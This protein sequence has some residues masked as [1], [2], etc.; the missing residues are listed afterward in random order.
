MLAQYCH[1]ECHGTTA[2]LQHK[3]SAMNVG[4]LGSGD[5]ARELASRLLKHDHKVQLGTRT[6]EKLS[7]WAEQN[8]G[9]TLGSFSSAAEFGQLLVLA[10]KGNA[11]AEVLRLAGTRNLDGKTVID[12]CHPISDARPVHGLSQFFTNHDESLME[13]L[14]REFS[15][16]HF[17][18]AYNSVGQRNRPRVANVDIIQER[19]IVTMR[20]L[21]AANP[22]P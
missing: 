20:S 15:N 12:A 4:V 17:V 2:R 18:K 19:F 7:E 8:P 21:I 16:A 13:Q 5:L 3:E 10:V 9:G 11:A 22:Q 1:V 14:Q 6:P